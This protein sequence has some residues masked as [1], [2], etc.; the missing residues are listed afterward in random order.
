MR[1][2]NIHL[3]NITH[4]IPIFPRHWLIKPKYHSI[5]LHQYNDST[6]DLDQ[7]HGFINTRWPLG[8]FSLEIKNFPGRNVYLVSLTLLQIANRDIQ[9]QVIYMQIS[10][11]QINI[12]FLWRYSCERP[13]STTGCSAESYIDRHATTSGGMCSLMLVVSC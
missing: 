8:L 11:K 13:N 12:E 3:I 4:L 10:W 6:N 5:I 9:G 2:N 1:N 7:I